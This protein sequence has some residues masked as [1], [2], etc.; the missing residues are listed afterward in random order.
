MRTIVCLTLLVVSWGWP[1]VAQTVLPIDRFEFSQAAPDLATAQSYTYQA[2][3]DALPPVELTATCE[4]TASPFVC[5]APLPPHV[6]GPHVAAVTT[7]IRLPDGRLAESPRSEPY[8][9]RIVVAPSA[10]TG[11]RIVP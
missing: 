9:Y 11:L 2:Y 10:P 8:A 1:A 7:A 4:G 6:T 5:R 3:I